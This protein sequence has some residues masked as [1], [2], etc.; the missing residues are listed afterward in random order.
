MSVS[1]RKFPLP[2]FGFLVVGAG[3]SDSPPH[4]LF[5]HLTFTNPQLR[6]LLA[7]PPGSA[8]SSAASPLVL[9][10]GDPLPGSGRPELR[11]AGRASGSSHRLLPRPDV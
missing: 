3:A 6:L 1:G 4:L 8:F 10:P 2:V 9:L 7:G 5:L 11:G